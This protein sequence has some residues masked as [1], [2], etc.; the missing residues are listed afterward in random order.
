MNKTSSALLGLLV[1]G[2]GLAANTSMAATTTNSMPVTSSVVAACK[3]NTLDISIPDYDTTNTS[4]FYSVNLSFS[5]N[6]TKGA[7]AVVS[8]DQGKN[9]AAGSTC[10]APARQLKASNGSLLSYDFWYFGSSAYHWGCGTANTG[11]GTSASINTG[12][13]L[14]LQVSVPRGQNVPA[15][16]YADQLTMTVSF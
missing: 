5:V 10:D 11:G 1:A 16:A 8:L 6:C 13:P 3:I 9:P 4:S 15:G 2:C 14:S 7:T 12:I